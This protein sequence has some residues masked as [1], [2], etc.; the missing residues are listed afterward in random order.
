MRARRGLDAAWGTLPL[1]T[2]GV[3]HSCFSYT[4]SSRLP[5][6]SYDTD[7]RGVLLTLSRVVSGHTQSASSSTPMIQ[8]NVHLTHHREDHL[9]LCHDDMRTFRPEFYR[10]STN[11]VRVLRGVRPGLWKAR[12]GCT[13]AAKDPHDLPSFEAERRERGRDQ[14][15]HCFFTLS[16]NNDPPAIHPFRLCKSLRC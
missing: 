1:V 11:P 5:L 15:L 8:S 3:A 4:A 9:M 2:H 14:R 10:A 16:R 12:V 13:L 7:S 6:R